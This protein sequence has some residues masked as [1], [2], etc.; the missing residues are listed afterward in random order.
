MEKKFCIVCGNEL[1]GQQ[2]K[3]C[4]AKCKQKDFYENH[5]GKSNV[6]FR[7]FIRYI[8][9]KL[10]FIELKGGKCE[11]CGYNEN[12]SALEFHHI[13][14]TTK[15]FNLNGRILANGRYEDLLEELDKCMLLCSNCHKEIHNEN[16]DIELVKQ[17][18]EENKDI[19]KK[20]TEVKYCK[21]CG[22]ILLNENTSGY[23]QKCLAKHRRKVERPTK[24][25]LQE[26][27]K[28]KSLNEIGKMYGVTHNSVK[29]WLISYDIWKKN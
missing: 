23:C 25:E 6:A 26:M 9:R 7:Q 12:L 28:D 8:K 10:E 1:K 20:E 14:S 27:I 18:L 16:Y 19:L 22:K 15:K 13:D 21:D 3:Y 11:K 4:S 29:K 17:I 2:Q 5:N 24:E